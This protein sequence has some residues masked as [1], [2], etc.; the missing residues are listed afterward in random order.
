MPTHEVPVMS[1]VAE[2]Q[3]QAATAEVALLGT[4]PPDDCLDVVDARLGFHHR[5]ELAFEDESIRAAEVAG[6]GHRHFHSEPDPRTE[7]TAKAS[8]K[9]EMRGITSRRSGRMEPYREVHPEHD[10]EQDK[11]LERKRGDFATFDPTDRLVRR[12]D[13]ATDFALA[14][15]GRDAS[16]SDLR[17]ETSPEVPRESTTS[18]QNCLARGHGADRDEW[19]CTSA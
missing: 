17:A 10:R 4:R 5:I 6:R 15:A 13:Q 16:D 11:A 12:A 2:Q 1:A 3:D 7:A 19:L 14:Q 9:C 8:E 18:L